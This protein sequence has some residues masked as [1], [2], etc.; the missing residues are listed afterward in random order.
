M[1][2]LKEN[3]EDESEPYSAVTIDEGQLEP[4]SD[5]EDT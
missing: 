2:P 5:D 3:K 4:R 1:L